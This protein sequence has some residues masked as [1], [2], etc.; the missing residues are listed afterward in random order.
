MDTTDKKIIQDIKYYVKSLNRP[1]NKIYQ[2]NEL[3]ILSCFSKAMEIVE[4]NSELRKKE[5]VHPYNDVVQDIEGIEGLMCSR[6][7]TKLTD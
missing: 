2:E 6:C 4:D 5:C 1:D 7:N 3:L